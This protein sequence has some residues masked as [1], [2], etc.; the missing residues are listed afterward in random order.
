MNWKYAIYLLL[1]LLTSLHLFQLYQRMHVDLNDMPID[2]RNLYLLVHTASKHDNF[3]IDKNVKRTWN[4]IASQED[5]ETTNQPG[6]PYSSMLYPPQA[7]TE[8][9]FYK[10]ISWKNYRWINYV[11]NFLLLLIIAFLVHQLSSKNLKALTILLPLLAF[12]GTWQAYFVG[13]PMFLCLAFILMAYYLWREKKHSWLAGI[14]LGLAAFKFTLVIPFGFFFL[15]KKDWKL[16]LASIITVLLLL[17]PVLFQYDL[18]ELLTTYSANA[19]E[20]ILQIYTDGG[21]N[22]LFQTTELA[23]LLF[24]GGIISANA[25]SIFNGLL[26]ILGIAFL[27]FNPKKYNDE[28]ILLLL[29]LWSFLFMYHLSYDGLVI[30]AFLV[31]LK[32]DKYVDLLKYLPFIIVFFLPING[33]MSRLNLSWE[34]F[35]LHMPIAIFAL[36]VYELFFNDNQLQKRAIIEN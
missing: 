16:V 11:Y 3:Y 8:F 12:K 25:V 31:I 29:I 13:Q 26:M 10:Y 28:S 9:Y 34:L 19:K 4:E 30:L 7:L 1:G 35:Y 5:F 15:Y 24:S 20:Q 27:L 14:M 6:L 21:N 33:I 36:L 17:A 23:S 2:A 22:L 18:V 32:F